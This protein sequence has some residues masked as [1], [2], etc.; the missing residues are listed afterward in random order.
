[1]KFLPS[2]PLEELTTPDH[3]W[4]VVGVLFAWWFSTGGILL[5]NGLR[6]STFKVS[7]GAVGAIAVAGVVGLWWSVGTTTTTAAWVG[8]GSALA[9]WGFHELAFLTG[10]LTGPNRDRCPPGLRGLDRFRAATATLV[11]HEVALFATL[12]VVLAVSWGEENQTGAA[13]FTVLWI[14]R[15]SSKLNLFVGVR[16]V[17]KQFIPKHLQHL[18]TYFGPT[19]LTPFLP[20]SI[21]VASL[22][23]ALCLPTFAAQGPAISATLVGTMLALGILEHV[24]LALPLADAALWRWA[25]RSGHGAAHTEPSDP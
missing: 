25:V 12:V 20:L 6:P 19:R 15:L 11:Y 24:F 22:A 3:I 2:G 18:V 16:Y 5:M 13:V 23:G 7:L 21:V 4:A 17:N 14:M 9:I 8:F 1:M 10:H